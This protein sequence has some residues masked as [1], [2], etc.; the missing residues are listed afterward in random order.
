MMST[1]VAIQPSFIP[2]LGYFDLIEK[3]STFIFYDH[4]QYD[5]NGWRNRNKIYRPKNSWQWLTIPVK[6]SMKIALKDVKIS[7]WDFNKKKILKSLKQYYS[8]HPNFKKTFSMVEKVFD[9]DYEKISDLC[10]DLIVE[11]CKHLQININYLRSSDYNNIKDKNLNLIEWCKRTQCSK[12]LTGKL[13]SN[14][15]QNDLFKKNKIQLLWHQYNHIRYNQIN[16]KNFISNLS[17]LDYL[18]NR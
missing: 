13:A 4:V 3:S 15:I 11:I 8:K 18:F 17:V 6:G 12:Y 9:K 1:L 2:W 14:Y 16:S 10:I 5:K 7:D